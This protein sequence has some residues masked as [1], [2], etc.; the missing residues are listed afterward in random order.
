MWIESKF[1]IVQDGVKIVKKVE[2]RL[3]DDETRS[4]YSITRKVITFSLESDQETTTK[5]KKKL[6]KY[7]YKVSSA[8]VISTTLHQI[9]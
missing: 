5:L 4:Y 7:G 6:T 3:Y 2:V 9:L 8:E 1:G